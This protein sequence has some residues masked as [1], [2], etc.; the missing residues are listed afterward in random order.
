[1]GAHARAAHAQGEHGAGGQIK[2]RDVQRAA[3][4]GPFFDLRTKTEGQS[5]ALKFRLAPSLMPLN[6]RAVTVL[7]LV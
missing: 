3:S 4:G 5:I 1:M 6:Q 2:A 7:V